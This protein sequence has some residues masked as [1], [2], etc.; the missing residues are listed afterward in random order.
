VENG[1]ERKGI[2]WNAPRKLTRSIALAPTL[3]RDGENVAIAWLITGITGN[4]PVVSSLLMTRRFMTVPS[5]FS[6]VANPSIIENIGFP[7]AP[8]A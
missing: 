5:V 2:L 7:G 1:E 4:C 8:L 6:S 3:A